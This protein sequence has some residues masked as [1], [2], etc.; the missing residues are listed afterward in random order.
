MIIRLQMKEKYSL[1]IGKSEV[2]LRT[3]WTELNWIW[4]WNEI[5]KARQGKADTDKSP[6]NSWYVSTE[7]KFQLI[8]LQFLIFPHRFCWRF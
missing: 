5:G 6:E 2:Y 3:N 8:M 7:T 1:F 4:R